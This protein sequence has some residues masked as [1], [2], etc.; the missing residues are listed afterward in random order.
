MARYT[1]NSTAHLRKDGREELFDTYQRATER[2]A[3]SKIYQL[4]SIVIFV[5]F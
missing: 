3:G 5:L 1:M 2:N 4:V